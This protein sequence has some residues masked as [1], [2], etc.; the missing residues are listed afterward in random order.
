MDEHEIIDSLKRIRS[1]DMLYGDGRILSSVSTKPLDV[2]VEAYN[3]FSDVNALDVHVFK[4]IEG[5][6]YDVVSWFG[7]LLN[8]KLI[9]GYVSSGGTESNIYA[10][11]A[12][13]KLYPKRKKILVPESAHYSFLKAADL[14]DLEIKWIPLDR[15]F[16]A[17]IPSIKEC[18]DQDT[19]AVVATAGTSALGV[20]DPIEAINNLCKETFFH[21]DA[22]FG[23]FVL[24]F[25]DGGPKFDFSL[26]NIDSIT[27]DPHK[28]GFVPMPSG[29]VFL[30]DESYLHKLGISP[31]YLPFKTYTLSGSRSGG[32]IAATWAAIK[33]L[34][35]GGYKRIVAECMKNTRILCSELGRLGVEILAEPELNFVGIRPND[36]EEI[37]SS[38]KA[39]G[40]NILMDKKTRSIR[41]VVMPHVSGEVIRSFISD[42]EDVI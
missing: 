36:L 18:I 14:L 24:P 21:V 39:K 32:A 4:S 17:D 11:W 42:L 27:V 35:V 22:A 13:K 3:V 41:I 16:K 20:V 6:E 2:A 7:G 29:A 12:A 28:M 33:Y 5:I 8:N 38:L 37:W 26:E 23:G 1:Q 10:L 34:G 25:L 9:A 31:T 40:W 30:R 19:L 15:G